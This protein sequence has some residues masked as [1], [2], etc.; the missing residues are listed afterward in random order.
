LLAACLLAAAAAHGAPAPDMKQARKLAEQLRAAQ[1]KVRRMLLDTANK[2]DAKDPAEKRVREVLFGLSQNELA[3]AIEGLEGLLAQP[4]GQDAAKRARRIAAAQDKAIDV[5]DEAGARVK[6]RRSASTVSI[7]E[8]EKKVAKSL[9]V[10][11]PNSLSKTSTPIQACGLL[12]P[13]SDHNPC[14]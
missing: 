12:K 7:R 11:L 13:Q 5:L 4:D 8:V 2:I 14:L 6:L 3:Q 9:P 1:V 10:A